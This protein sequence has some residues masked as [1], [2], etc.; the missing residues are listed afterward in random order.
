MVVGPSWRVSEE[1]TGC[2]VKPVLQALYIF[3]GVIL[4]LSTKTFLQDSCLALRS[5]DLCRFLRAL[6]RAM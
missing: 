4:E 1:G 3:Q 2:L 5:S 6:K